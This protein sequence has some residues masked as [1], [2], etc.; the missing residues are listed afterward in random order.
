[1]ITSTTVLQLLLL[2]MMMTIMTM[3]CHC[4]MGVDNGKDGGDKFPRIW[5]G[6]R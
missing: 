6:G 4:K 1:M 2:L 5:S 3:L